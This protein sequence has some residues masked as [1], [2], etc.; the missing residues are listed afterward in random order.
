MLWAW[1]FIL[2]IIF[3]FIPIS[4]MPHP[5]EHMWSST[6]A[7]PLTHLPYLFTHSPAPALTFLTYLCK[8]ISLTQGGQ[9]PSLHPPH[10]WGH[11]CPCSHWA[12]AFTPHPP[13]SLHWHP[14][15][16]HPIEGRQ[17]GTP[18]TGA[19]L[20]GGS[21]PHTHMFWGTLR[22]GTC[23]C[24]SPRPSLHPLRPQAVY[25]HASHHP[26]HPPGRL[27][28]RSHLPPRTIHCT[29]WVVYA[30]AH[31]QAIY[32]HTH[33]SPL[34]PSTMP[35]QAVYAHTCT[36][37]LTLAGT[38]KLD[39]GL[40][41]KSLLHCDYP[42]TR[43]EVCLRYFTKSLCA[44]VFMQTVYSTVVRGNSDWVCD[45]GVNLTNIRKSVTYSV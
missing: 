18:A 43:C 20:A 40:F 3:H 32:A 11:L 22:P 29:P 12:P 2:I 7:T 4:I 17:D 14:L 23:E 13:L 16:P 1:L 9:R 36:S 33:T 6:I 27:C 24:H 31:T 44:M 37:P 42:T 28:P 30:H 34:A 26:P 5:I 38:P 25:A 8:T 19:A 35:P 45:K 41:S 15:Q 21:H 39:Y 10:P